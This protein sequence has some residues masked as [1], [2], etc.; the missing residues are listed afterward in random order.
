M[1][2]KDKLQEAYR[3]G[4]QNAL[5]EQEQRPSTTPALPALI[6]KTI[7]DRTGQGPKKIAKRLLKGKGLP[8][9]IRPKFTKQQKKQ[10]SDLLKIIFPDS[11]APDVPRPL[12]SA[13]RG[14][15]LKLLSGQP[16]TFLERQI[17]KLLNVDLRGLLPDIEDALNDLFDDLPD[18]P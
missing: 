7:K 16:L 2:F 10:L 13:L 15:I 8:T 3:Q 9:G 11:A 14:I 4:Y 1:N 6:R 18:D 17:L 5:S 12:L